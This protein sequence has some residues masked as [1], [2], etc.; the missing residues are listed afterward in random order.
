MKNKLLKK[1]MI[2]GALFT[3]VLSACGSQT[4][5]A[6]DDTDIEEDDEDEDDDRDHNE[7]DEEP[8]LYAA[9]EIDYSS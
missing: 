6:D 8:P 2:L 1:L 9:K 7:P 3:L 4:A 5:L